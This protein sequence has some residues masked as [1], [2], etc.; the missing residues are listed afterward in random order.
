MQVV[1]IS[2]VL[3]AH[4]SF[5]RDHERMLEQVMNFGEAMVLREV[6]TNPGFQPRTGALQRATKV[7]TIRTRRGR[8]LRVSNPKRYA[9]AIDG[10]ARPHVIVARPGKKLAFR[11]RDGNMVFRKRVNHPGNRAYRFL[12]NPVGTTF[13][14]LQPQLKSGMA[15]VAANFRR[16]R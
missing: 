11:G 9:R 3:R 10:G 5:E 15:R 8:L 7:R 2:G 13:V 14:R 4:K 16:A 6:R 1:D 12:R